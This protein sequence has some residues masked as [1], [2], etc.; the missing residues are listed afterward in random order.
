VWLSVTDLGR[1]VGLDE[2]QQKLYES[3][4]IRNFSTE[5]LS[6]LLRIREASGSK[7]G[8]E[9]GYPDSGFSWYFFITECKCQDSNLNYAKTASFYTL[10]SSL[11]I[12]SPDAIWS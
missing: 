7:L 6:L 12:L 1:V 11:I 10:S 9:T 3:S 2:S 4:V 8:M 5:W